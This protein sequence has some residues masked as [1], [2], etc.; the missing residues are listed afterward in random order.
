MIAFNI[1]RF[2]L[3]SVKFSSTG[4]GGKNFLSQPKSYRRGENDNKTLNT[5]VAMDTDNYYFRNLHD[6]EL[7][8]LQLRYSQWVAHPRL[9]WQKFSRW[10]R[11]AHI[12]HLHH[13]TFITAQIISLRTHQVFS[14]QWNL[15]TNLFRIDL[16]GIGQ[17]CRGQM[18]NPQYQTLQSQ[19]WTPL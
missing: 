11:R 14:I 12:Q 16:P 3:G 9:R 10:T 18:V 17:T 8:S 13:M 5:L 4:N 1:V 19:T 6:K 2:K 7:L 15:Y